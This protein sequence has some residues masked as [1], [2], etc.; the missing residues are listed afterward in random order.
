MYICYSLLLHVST[1][2]G[3]SSDNTYHLG[4]PLHTHFVFCTYRHI[5]VIVAI[6]NNYYIY[7][8]VFYRPPLWSSSQEFL[9]T[10]PEIQ[11]S[12]PGA[13]RFSEK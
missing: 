10:D 3:P 7:F 2:N 5:F 12:I 11:G 8:S 1:E 13:T 9:A 4:N 6:N